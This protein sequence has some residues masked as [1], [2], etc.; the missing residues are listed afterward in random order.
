[1]ARTIFYQALT[2]VIAGNVGNT[3]A[4]G[5]GSWQPHNPIVITKPFLTSEQQFQALPLNQPPRPVDA[6]FQRAHP[7]E[8]F[9]KPFPAALQQWSSFQP[10][11][12]I[13]S[14]FPDGWKALQQWDQALKKPFPVAL[15]PYAVNDPVEQVPTAVTPHGWEGVQYEIGFAKPFPVALQKFISEGQTRQLPS[16]IV[17]LGWWGIQLEYR[18]A[19]PFPVEQQQFS[20][21]DLV[22]DVPPFLPPGSGKRYK[23]P[24]NYLPEP[25]YDA[26]P[27]KPFRP[28]WD[29]P[30]QGVVEQ[31]QAA[32]AGPPPLP[33][34]ELFGTPG[35]AGAAKTLAPAAL[36]LPSFVHFAPEDPLGL[37]RRMGEVQ[38]K[39]DALAVLKKLGLIRDNN[40]G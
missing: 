11:G 20:V 31:P 22:G 10:A 13:Q 5:A 36:K 26:K 6:Q 8:Q 33:P 18:F 28:V 15:Q 30:K 3:V 27:S 9:K 39:N 7:P 34:A 37:S 19:K 40:P 1:M 4:G 17:P 29:K 24:T 35:H 2:L 14:S 16:P 21:W 23:Y 32:P 25:A 12:F 38:D